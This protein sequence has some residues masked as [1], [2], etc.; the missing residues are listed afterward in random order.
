MAP[1]TTVEVGDPRTT[2]QVA[3]PINGRGTAMAASAVTRI[4][5]VVITNG[6]SAALIVVP[7]ASPT[8]RSRISR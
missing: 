5:A 4:A 2:V 8:G 7:D 1:Q 6:A 3:T